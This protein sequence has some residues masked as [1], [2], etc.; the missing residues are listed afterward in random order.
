M[1]GE[2]QESEFCFDSIF[3]L[4]EIQ[5]RFY[6]CVHFSANNNTQQN[7]NYWKQNY[8]CEEKLRR[9]YFYFI[10]KSRSLAIIIAILIGIRYDV[11]VNDFSLAF[12][13]VYLFL[14]ISIFS[15]PSITIHEHAKITAIHN[16]QTAM[17]TTTNNKKKDISNTRTSLKY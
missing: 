2:A 16:Q 14:T 1:G 8:F 5:F 15:L 9:F 17:T 10:F 4:R 12:V 7:T 6:L 13:R 11:V 3:A